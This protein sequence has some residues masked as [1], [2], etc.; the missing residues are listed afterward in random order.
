MAQ[1]L[2]VVSVT[3]TITSGSAYASGNQLGG[4]M[5]VSGVNAG[6][7]SGCILQDVVVV[8][9]AGQNAAMDVL[10]FDA[11]V[12]V[13][14]DK[15]AVSISAADLTNHCLGNLKVTAAMYSSAG[16][17]SVA[18]FNG[19]NMPLTVKPALGQGGNTGTLYAVLVCRGTPT[20]TSTSDITVKFKF[21]FEA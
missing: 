9:K 3:P 1:Q 14:S 12:T 11:S 19:S 7:S 4:L 5:T 13:G 17:P 8:D 21:G 20:Y 6:G 18:T 16:T 10:V 15:A 2:H